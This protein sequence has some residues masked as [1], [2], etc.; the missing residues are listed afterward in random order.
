MNLTPFNT[1]GSSCTSLERS[2]E[3]SVDAARCQLCLFLFRIM[4]FLWCIN[5][6]RLIGLPQMLYLFL[7]FTA[8]SQNNK[9]D[10]ITD[11]RCLY[12]VNGE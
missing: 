11:V 6:N 5:S 4:T 10:I 9:N 1:K 7:V 2:A 8:G 12:L 3:C